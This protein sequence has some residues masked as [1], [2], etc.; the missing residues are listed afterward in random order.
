MLELLIY[1]LAKSRIMSF[2]GL[3]QFGAKFFVKLSKNR[4]NIESER[5]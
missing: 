5:I 4:N 2:N 1:A 3:K